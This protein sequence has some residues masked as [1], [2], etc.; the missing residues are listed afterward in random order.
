MA[1]TYLKF[2]RGSSPDVLAGPKSGGLGS[3]SSDAPLRAGLGACEVQAT[4]KLAEVHSS[5]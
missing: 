5:V 1:V 4:S 2:K 3:E